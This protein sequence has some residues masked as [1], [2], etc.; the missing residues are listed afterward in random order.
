M[1]PLKS[2]DMDKSWKDMCLELQVSNNHLAAQLDRAIENIV[3]EQTANA[4]L[5]QKVEHL[6]NSVLNFKKTFGVK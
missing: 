6:S 3:A 1:N 2:I 4:L 5:T